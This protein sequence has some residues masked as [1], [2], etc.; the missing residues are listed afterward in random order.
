MR[1][2]H[3]RHCSLQEAEATTFL[4]LRV[5]CCNIL[6]LVSLVIIIAVFVNIGILIIIFIVIVII[7]SLFF[8]FLVDCIIRCQCLPALWWS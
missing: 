1:I 4:L 5:K 2:P 3:H 7:L 8:R 6:V